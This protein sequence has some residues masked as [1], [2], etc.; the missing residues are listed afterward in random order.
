MQRF[1]YDRSSKWLIQHHGGA[2]LRL[3]GLTDVVSWRPL[4][5]ELVQPRQL[6]DGLLEVRRTG[7]SD[8]DLFVVEVATYPDHRV[9]EQLLQDAAL[10]YL[11]RGRHPEVVAIVLRP[12]GAVRV[13]GAIELTSPAGWTHWQ[14][15]WRA[16]ELWT[17]PAADV[18]ALG[19][20]GLMPWVPLAQYDGPAELIFRQCRA[21]IDRDAKPEE[22]DN[23]LAVTTVLAGLRYNDRRLLALLGGKEAMIDSPILIEFV[24]ERMHKLVLAA[25]TARFGPV[26]DDI[27]QSLRTV[28]DEDRLEA[29][30]V[31]AVLCTDFDAFRRELTTVPG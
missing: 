18:L 6:P 22:R 17:V 4:Q 19:D 25:L 27:R 24:A 5:A 11:D 9:P 26:P 23:L 21:I 20:V 28:L 30:N 3:A 31:V 2:L 10:V 7:R 14:A 12:K 8:P 16:V 1:R 29:L 15:S 13:A